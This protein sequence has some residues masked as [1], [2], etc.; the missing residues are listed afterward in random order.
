[1]RK[2]KLSAAVAV[3]LTALT[4]TLTAQAHFR[5]SGSRCE[6]VQIQPN[7]DYTA[8]DIRSKGAGCSTARRLAKSVAK[9]MSSLG[10]YCRWRVRNSGDA[11]NGIAHTDYRCV[12]GSR[13]VVFVVS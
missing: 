9:S 6:S 10:Y 3:A 7:T 2:L 8:F 4:F 5:G 12:R 11:S 13:V 1:M